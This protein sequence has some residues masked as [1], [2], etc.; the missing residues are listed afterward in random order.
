ME[1]E[2]NMN[3]S[4]YSEQ[5]KKNILDGG[6][7]VKFEYLAEYGSKQPFCALELKKVGGGEVAKFII[8]LEKILE[9]LKKEYPM[10]YAL[11]KMLVKISAESVTIQ[12]DKNKKEN[13]K[14]E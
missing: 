13:K 7:Y 12:T 10:E 3:Y 11:G 2:I 14:D 1:N 9:N 5:W 6:R 4:E 8:A